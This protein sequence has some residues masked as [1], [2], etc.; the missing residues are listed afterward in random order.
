M[1]AVTNLAFVA[2]GLLAAREARRTGRLDALTGLLC[3]LAVAIGIGSFL[4]HTFAQRWAGLA[5]VLPILGFIVVYLLAAARRLFG[6]RWVLAIPA[7]ALAFAAAQFARDGALWAAGGSLNGSE[8]YAPALALLAGA[9]ILLAVLRRAAAAPV[10][11]A[12][13]VFALSLA[14]RS[15]DE[16]LCAALP[17]GTHFGWH[18]LNGLMIGILLLALIRHGRA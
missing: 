18:L 17:L 3:A 8:N 10:A 14:M 15:A 9:A 5:D 2:A 6:L 13:G 4:F 16:A 1:N 7:A 12:A 11:V